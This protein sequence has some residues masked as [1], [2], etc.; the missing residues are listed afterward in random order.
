VAAGVHND[1]QADDRKRQLMAQSDSFIDTHSLCACDARCCTPPGNC[2]G[3]QMQHHCFAYIAA[4]IAAECAAAAAAAAAGRSMTVRLMEYCCGIYNAAREVVKVVQD[5][6][7]CSRS[8]RWVTHLK[9][10]ISK[11]WTRGGWKPT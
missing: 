11:L 6:H 7:L 1:L 3:R 9:A 4:L 5:M 8:C 10:C 2:A